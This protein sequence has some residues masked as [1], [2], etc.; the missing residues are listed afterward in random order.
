MRDVGAAALRSTPISAAFG[1]CEV[2]D[3]NMANAA[4][5]HAVENG[6]NIS[7]YVMI[8]FGGAAPLHAAR[9]CEKLG[10]DRC[11]V[12]QGAGVGSAIGFLKAPFGYEALA[13]RLVRLSQFDAGGGQSRCLPSS[14]PRPKASSGRHQ[15]R[16]RA[17]RSRPSCAMRARDGRSRSPLPDAPFGDGRRR[18]AS[19][20]LPDDITQ[21]FFGRAIDGLDGLEIEIVTWSVKASDERADVRRGTRSSHGERARAGQP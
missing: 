4:R 11:L 19:E 14:R 15:R 21:R 10:I 12:P 6:K 7:D 18:P 2:V 16:D 3:E 8:A 17:S 1:I 20:L 5:V 13:S 9:L